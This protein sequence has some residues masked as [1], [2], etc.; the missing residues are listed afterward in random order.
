[1]ESK[2]NALS[3]CPIANMSMFSACMYKSMHSIEVKGHNEFYSTSLLLEIKNSFAWLIF[4][5]M[6][7][8][9]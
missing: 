4:Y 9:Y 2:L 7:Y 5:G 1:M 6:I 8:T 3:V